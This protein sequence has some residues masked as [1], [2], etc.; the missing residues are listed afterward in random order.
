MQAQ[1]STL[2]IEYILATEKAAKQVA[3]VFFGDTNPFI[4]HGYGS[5]GVFYGTGDVDRA[6]GFGELDRIADQ[7]DQD[8][9]E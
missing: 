7:V 4:A 5:L 9:T 8:V 2:Y 1:A 3:L 6:V